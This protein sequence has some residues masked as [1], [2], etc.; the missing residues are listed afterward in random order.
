MT[1][2]AR[3]TGFLQPLDQAVVPILALVVNLG[4]GDVVGQKIQ[5]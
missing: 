4:R 5:G 2:S 3:F 1:H